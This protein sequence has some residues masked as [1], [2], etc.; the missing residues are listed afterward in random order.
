[1]GGPQGQDPLLQY[2]V[3]AV[4]AM[5]VTFANKI[6]IGRI[7]AVPFFIATV[8]YYSPQKDYLRFVALGIFLFAVISDGVDGYIARTQ[9]QKTE[10]GAILDPL[11]D[12]LLLISAFICLYKMSVLFDYVRFPIWLVVAV[13]SRDVMLLLGAMIIQII[14]GKLTIEPTLWGKATAFFEIL[15]VFGILLQWPLSEAF[16][17]P[18]FVLI[19]ISGID[20]IRKGIKILNGDI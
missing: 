20:Y 6:T 13:I 4:N 18:A 2:S 11:A 19:I 9:N 15:C 17:G 12:K 10:A 1:M 8:L 3:V 14:R 16:W 5:N 7:L